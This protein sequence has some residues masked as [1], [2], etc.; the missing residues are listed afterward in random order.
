MEILNQPDEDE[1]KKTN[2]M[3]SLKKFSLELVKIGKQVA[4]DVISEAIKKSMGL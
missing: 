2:A 1:T 4:A 3:N